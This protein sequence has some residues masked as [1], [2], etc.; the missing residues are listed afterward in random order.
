VIEDHWTLHYGNFTFNS[1]PLYLKTTKHLEN[2]SITASSASLGVIPPWL[3]K[4]V[5]IDKSLSNEV[6]KHDSPI[7]L[8]SLALENIGNY[9]NSIHV[10][11]DASKLS[12]GNVGIGIY[13]PHLQISVSERVS[14]NVSIFAGELTA[15][16]RSIEIYQ[17]ISNSESE[18]LSIFS[19]SLSVIQSFDSI[20]PCCRQNLLTSVLELVTKI[21]F[22]IV[23]IWVPSHIGIPGNEE[24]DKLALAGASLPLI[25]NNINYELSDANIQIENYIQNSWQSDWSKSKSFYQT[26]EE[27]VS[28]KIKF[29][30]KS[31]KKEVILTRLRLGKC[32]LNSYLHQIKLHPTGLCATCNQPETIDHHLLK[33]NNKI[34]KHLKE[35]CRSLKITPSLVNVLKNETIL[36]SITSLI[37]R[38]L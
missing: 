26:V 13:F 24:A 17:Q 8:K 25:Q 34:S 11:T 20:K 19:D 37:D 3:Y 28:K 21:N 14:N 1:K 33:C 36:D 18:N 2:L 12:N 6:S 16:K 35:L 29:T 15:I 9:S 7:V 32:K 10:Y 27:N 38:S 4:P 30:N 22:K 31:R 23:V 5:E